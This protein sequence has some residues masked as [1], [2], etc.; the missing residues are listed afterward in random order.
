MKNLWI[1]ALLI[2]GTAF[3]AAAEK[4]DYYL[5]DGV[6]Y[7]PTI[8]KPQDAF[9][10]D[11]G[12]QPARHDLMVAYFRKLA[13]ESDRITIE[14]IG[15]SHER[16][17]ILT[18][19][20]THPDNHARL[21]DIRTAHLKRSSADTADEAGDD[22]PVITWLN[23]GVHGAESSGMDA[24]I[25]SL[26]HLA[27]A[28]D[29]ETLQALRNS[30]V[31]F[32]AV[33]NPDGHSRRISWVTSY[34]SNVLA[35][36]PD[37]EIHNHRWPGGR[38]NHY[39]FDLNRQWMLQTQPESQAWL[40]QWHKWK[41]HVTADYHEMGGNSTYYFHPGVP[42]RKN[43]L[44][45]AKGRSL[46]V[47]IA[48]Y[49]A[50]DLDARQELYFT[51]EGFDNFYVG[52]GSTYPQVNGGLGILF[53]AGA[54]M[55]IARESDQG[56]KTYSRNIRTQFRTSLTTIKGA[57]AMREKLHSYQREFYETARKE[58]RADDVKAYVFRT[59]EDDPIRLNLFLDLMDRHHIRI[60]RLSAD[61]KADGKTFPAG[62]YA[63]VMDQDQYRM[64]RALF[65]HFT[66][67]EENIFYDVSGW[68]MPAAYGLEYAPVRASVRGKIGT[69][70][71]ATFAAADIPDEA[72]YAY[73]F[74]WDNYYAPRAV[75]RLLQAGVLVRVGKENIRVQ[76]TKGAVNMPRGAVIVPLDRQTVSP[77][78]IH[79][80]IRDAATRDGITVHA[81]TSGHTLG[82]GADLGGRNSVGDLRA[83]HVLLV[84]GPGM[85]VYDAGEVWHTL[86]KRMEIPVT[87]VRKERMK[88]IRNWERYTHVVLVGGTNVS[89]DDTVT[90]DLKDWLADG[91]TLIASR[92]GAAWA[93]EHITVQEDG[94]GKKDTKAVKDDKAPVRKSYASKSVEDA[95]HVIGGAVFASSLDTTH[96]VAFGV[97]LDT[98]YTNKN[99]VKLLP[100]PTDPYAQVAVYRDAPLVSGYASEKRLDELKGTPMLTAERMGRGAVILFAD[101]PN[102]RATYIGSE[103]LFMNAV[104]FSRIFDRARGSGDTAGHT[105]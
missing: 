45:P 19:V 41:P 37:H 97:R 71:T 95:K 14:T 26:Y 66:K 24:A 35:L 29:P 62:S 83:P 91:G 27:A 55:G 5:L 77:G 32:T 76:T 72:P 78:A 34:G 70:V 38:T 84:T 73:V 33:F 39:W 90:A 102:F 57:V 3:S 54:Q 36:D 79:E 50:A 80:L 92:E 63:V 81:A 101:N 60:N 43:P 23:F 99:T 103:K 104:F 67:F 86:D 31:V 2:F 68:T 10:H 47:E 18:A 4:L 64:V 105:H 49:H 59:V 40:T 12:D 85:N 30:V 13:A 65:G 51:E 88:N 82:A 16:R 56:I 9:G 75:N 48:G 100:V 21:E 52:K 58:A 15:Y 22:L 94:N 11:I 93:A 61:V 46:L 25:P 6:S 96:P 53:E 69:A 87:L 42:T 8:T 28:E 74:S 20:I 89:L 44:I 98:V 1:T 17:P 7:D